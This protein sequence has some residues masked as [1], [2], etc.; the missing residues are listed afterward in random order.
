MKIK[1]LF[2]VLLILAFITGCEHQ[3]FY[4]CDSWSDY[5]SYQIVYDGRYYMIK[6]PLLNGQYYG[7]RCLTFEAAQK[8][9]FKLMKLRKVRCEEIKKN[10]K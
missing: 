2:W 7:G 6:D 1:N 4:T 5:N 3:Y 9:I 8:E 10:D